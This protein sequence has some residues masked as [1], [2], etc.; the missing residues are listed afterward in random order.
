MNEFTCTV[1][2]ADVVLSG[3]HRVLKTERLLKQTARL[4]SID[5][6]LDKVAGGVLSVLPRLPSAKEDE[7][8]AAEVEEHTFWFTLGADLVFVGYDSPL[9]SYVSEDSRFVTFLATHPTFTLRLALRPAV[10]PKEDFAK[11]YRLSLCDGLYFPCLNAKQ[12]ELVT[13]EDKHVLVQGVAGSGKTNVC[14][15]KI[16]FS[17]YRAYGGKV[18]YTTFSRGLLMDTKMRL[19]SWKQTALALLDAHLAGRV[20]FADEDEQGGIANRLGLVLDDN[21]SLAFASLAAIIERM[22]AV[23]YKLPQDLYADQTGRLPLVCDEAYFLHEFV[24]KNRSALAGRM[25]KIKQL[26]PEVIYKEIFGLIEGWCDPQD[27]AKRLDRASYIAMRQGSFGRAECDVIFGIAEEYARHRAKTGGVTEAEMCRA[28]LSTPLEPYSL[29]IA[30]EV[31]DFCQVTL[32]LL[33]RLAQKMFCVGDALQMINPSFFNFA[34]LK[35]LLFDSETSRVV[36]LQ[37]NYRSSKRIEGLL[38]ELSALNERC[39]GVH[40]FVVKGSVVGDDVDTTAALVQGDGL[41]QAM[42]ETDLGDVTIVVADR[43]VKEAIRPLLPKQEILTVSEIKGLERDT[44]VL[45]HLLDTHRARWDALEHA[46][47]DRKTADE[48]SVYRYYFNLFYVGVSRARRHLYVAEEQIPPLFRSLAARLDKVSEQ[49]AVDTLHKVA[50][51]RLDESEVRARVEQFLSL[52]QYDNA[53]VAAA[54]LPDAVLQT[55]RIAVYADSVRRGDY[56]NAGIAFWQLGLI[57]DATKCFVMGSEEALLDLMRATL[58]QGESRLQVGMLRYYPLLEGN[59]AAQSALVGVVQQ[60]L[61][62]LKEER[63]QVHAAVKSRK[64]GV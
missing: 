17:A 2:S 46:Y 29:V 18:L 30:D 36:T 48:N 52:G 7:Y 58:V 4:K 47:V 19:E 43:A 27:P 10:Y 38:D 28:L 54:K 8:W 15:D 1:N 25:E 37:H 57:E 22:D 14:V 31:Q 53:R 11:L 59:E 56:R 26:S 3:R 50:G 24:G 12:R 39:F 61:E 23:E 60:E 33:A 13:C 40:S 20:R 35:R 9:E 5:D 32:V 42:A 64:K 62:R 34:Y 63:K 49:T 55:K 41:L 45:Y 51:K 6:M 21:A 16:L 44:V